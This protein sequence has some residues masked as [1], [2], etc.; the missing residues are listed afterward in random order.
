MLVKGPAP[1]DHPD[2]IRNSLDDLEHGHLLEAEVERLLARWMELVGVGN[3]IDVL[4]SEACLRGI[5]KT[6]RRWSFSESVQL[7][8]CY[9]L[10]SVAARGEEQIRLIAS[11]GG[12]AAVVEALKKHPR[13][14]AVQE[15]GSWALRQLSVESQC[16]REMLV[17][18]GL[19]AILDA[20]CGHPGS[21]GVLENACMALA[22]LAAD[23]EPRICIAQAGGVEA[24]VRTMEPN[25]DSSIIQ[26]AACFFLHNMAC[27]K[28][29]QQLIAE[30]GGFEAAVEAMRA[31]P[32]HAGV[33]KSGCGVFHNVANGPIQCLEAVSKCSAVEAV[34]EAMQGHP[35]H[36]GVQENA[37]H[38]LGQVGD[39]RRRV[40]ELEDRRLHDKIVALGGAEALR[41]ATRNFRRD[42]PAKREAEEALSIL[43]L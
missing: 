9:I 38:A 43:E 31:H 8:G 6:M 22:N 2:E 39:V 17:Q 35:A 23:S 13:S 41:K 7:S 25:A 5:I 19:D 4:S 37:A 21:L 33:Q 18:G 40:V 42:A 30:S 24:V 20:L 15:K 16:R 34:I 29:Y 14:E 32:G 1:E 3:C 10:G 12:V 28:E 26:E 27:T 11:L 36:D